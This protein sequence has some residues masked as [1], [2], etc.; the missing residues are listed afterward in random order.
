[1]HY[2]CVCI[3]PP[4]GFF[5]F[6]FRRLVASDVNKCRCGSNS[7]IHYATSGNKVESR[8]TKKRSLHDSDYSRRWRLLLLPS[9]GTHTE[10]KERLRELQKKKQ[11]RASRAR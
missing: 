2:V 9:E 4:P 1:M 3:T 6:F 11:Q 10:E 8:P 5:F 7:A